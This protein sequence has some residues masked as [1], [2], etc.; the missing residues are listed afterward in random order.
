MQ[1][2]L[3]ALAHLVSQKSSTSQNNTTTNNNITYNINYMI[4]RNKVA[5]LPAI[6]AMLLKDIEEGLVEAEYDDY[7][8]DEDEEGLDEVGLDEVGLDEVGLDEVGLDEV[9]YNH[10]LPAL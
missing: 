9:V 4:Q 5:S 2:Q 6:Q 7:I 10:G 1:N 8:E 3:D